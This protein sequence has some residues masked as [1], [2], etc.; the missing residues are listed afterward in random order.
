MTLAGSWIR[1]DGGRRNERGPRRS[2]AGR[3]KAKN[4]KV[5]AEARETQKGTGCVLSTVPDFDT[6]SEFLSD[7]NVRTCHDGRGCS[8]GKTI[9]PR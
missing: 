1:Y 3:K 7:A 9:D 4:W 6:N 8:D 2:R 5:S